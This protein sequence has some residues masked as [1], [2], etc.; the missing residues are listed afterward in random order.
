MEII[1]NKVKIINT[2]ESKL[3][4]D[5]IPRY[6]KA[7]VKGPEQRI[8][9]RIMQTH[10]DIYQNK[11]MVDNLH[12]LLELNPE[13]EYV[14]YDDED[15]KKFLSKYLG[16]RYSNAFD[17]IKPGAFKGDYFRYAYL[18]IKGGVYLDMDLKVLSSLKTFI[19]TRDEF[20]SCRDRLDAVY[21][22]IL[23]CVPGHFLIRDFLE[24]STENIENEYYGVN[25]LDIT[26]PRMCS[27]I[28]KK[29]FNEPIV[30]KYYNETIK[31][32]GFKWKF[33][34]MNYTVMYRNRKIF[35]AKLESS[36]HN[37]NSSYGIMWN[38][39]NVYKK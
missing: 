3:L 22:A 20:I 7:L 32:L 35:D 33:M 28:F 10:K 21:N 11:N 25:A 24:K 36:I 30:E 9:Y 8:P 29:Y 5:T 37:I 31:L 14:F 18:Y 16:Q 1:C 13:Y 12:K 15:C 27:R 39:R 19:H 6:R 38:K 17:K 23:C 26:G 4:R 2:K 34:S